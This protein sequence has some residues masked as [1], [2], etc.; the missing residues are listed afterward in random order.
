MVYIP[1]CIVEID[2]IHRLR[3]RDS[4]CCSLIP[5]LAVGDQ[6]CISYIKGN[7]DCRF[8]ILIHRICPDAQIPVTSIRSLPVR[9]EPSAGRP[10]TRPCGKAVIGV[11]RIP[12]CHITDGVSSIGIARCR[13]KRRT[14]QPYIVMISCFH[15]QTAAVTLSSALEIIVFNR[16]TAAHIDPAPCH[17]T[18]HIL[19]NHIKIAVF[20]CRIF[21]DGL[22]GIAIYTVSCCCKQQDTQQNSN[23]HG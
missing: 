15:N 19:Q 20:V 18:T 2:R 7:I 10:L 4:Q 13:C 21:P 23:Q 17:L 11:L 5:C 8:R 12:E 6:S 16:S 22:A 1:R 9:T 3:I 14:V